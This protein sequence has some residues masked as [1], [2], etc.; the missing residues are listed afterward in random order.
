MHH[1]KYTNGHGVKRHITFKAD[2]F[3]CLIAFLR[4]LDKNG[5]NCKHYFEE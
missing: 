1:I 2:E 5:I 3:K 4:L